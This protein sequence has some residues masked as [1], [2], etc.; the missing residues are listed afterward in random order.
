[1]VTAGFQEDPSYGGVG[2][3]WVQE[4]GNKETAQAVRRESGPAWPG[5]WEGK[6]ILPA[7]HKSL[8]LS[9][10][11]L[12]DLWLLHSTYRQRR[13]LSPPP[14]PSHSPRI[15]VQIHK[16]IMHISLSSLC[17][18][19]KW[20]DISKSLQ[21]ALN[22]VWNEKFPSLC[23]G[24]LLPSN[25]CLCWAGYCIIQLR[26]NQKLSRGKNFGITK[27]KL[28]LKNIFIYWD[29]YGSFS[30]ALAILF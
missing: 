17:V 6:Q 16:G 21:Q 10:Q 12:G 20:P 1:M 13:N 23:I 19:Q 30:L 9:S 5:Q 29:I 18:L 4:T 22:D 24:S 15:S 8:I 7:G 14:T 3:V 2:W 25:T 27:T 11:V 26:G 28:K